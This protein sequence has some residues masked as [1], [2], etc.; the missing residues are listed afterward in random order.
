MNTGETTQDTGR[1]FFGEFDC[2]VDGQ[3]RLALP[4]TWR[5]D[6]QSRNH[7]FLLSGRDGSLQLVP[8]DM[9]MELLQ[10]LRK[11]SFADRDASRA[12]AA[13]GSRAQECR[14]DKQGRFA[15]GPKLMAQ[16]GITDRA[17][18]VGAVTTVQVWA[19]GKWEAASVDNEAGLD[20]IQNIQ[21]QPGETLLE[22]LRKA[23]KG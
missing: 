17:V 12:F 19:P 6:D 16:A 13:L 10:Q 4:S 21:Q 7:F 3:R 8:A 2:A 18:L 1:W 15:L 22:I 5:D 23:M 14:C 20:V 9:F 11:V